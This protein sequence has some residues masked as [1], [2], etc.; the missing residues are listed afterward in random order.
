MRIR[1]APIA[2][3]AAAALLAGCGGG[4]S[5]TGGESAAGLVPADAAAFVSVNTDFSSGQLRSAD[6]VLAKFPIRDEVLEYARK[7]IREY[8]IDVDALRRSAGPEIDLAVLDEHAKLAAG[9]TRP[10]D[11]ERFDRLL[12]RKGLLHA[13]KSGWTVFARDQGALDAVK[14]AEEKLADAPA[15]E[16]ATAKLPDEA[17]AKAYVA[18][19]IVREAKHARWA[20]AALLSHDDGFELQLHLNARGLPGAESY[21]A[22]L[23]DAIPDGSVAALSFRDFGDALR[24]LAPATIPFLGVRVDELASAFDGEGILYVRPGALI[25]EVALVT[26]GGHGAAAL[27][28]V[29]RALAPANAA[30]TKTSI[31]GVTLNEL[32]LG[33]VSIL[34]GDVDG[35]LVVTDNANAIRGLKTGD[36]PK[37][38]EDDATFEAARDAV[39]MP[40]ETNGWLYLN[41][42]DGL[43]LVEA[44][45]E[46]ANQK[47]PKVWAENLRAVRSVL[48]FGTRKGD[49]QT[50]VAFVQ[51]R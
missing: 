2:A 45:A 20:S 21:R 35:K 32:V 37:L 29:V 8:G 26:E 28:R 43:P 16:H 1:L 17:I 19:R 49:V 51:T 47:L 46:L 12:D 36:R 11:E 33:V 42:E 9:F 48:V 5:A 18:G 24:R 23:A 22:D 41:V 14:R 34:Y 44:I 39:D 3:A 7:A 4:G 13:R 27:D 15:Y 30:P 25:P 10:K 31:E 50:L 38:T 40:D 6:D